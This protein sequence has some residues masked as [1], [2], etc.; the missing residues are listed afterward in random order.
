MTYNQ[1]GNNQNQTTDNQ[2]PI[3]YQ[4]QTTT[5]DQ[6]NDPS[7]NNGLKSMISYNNGISAG[8]IILIILQRKRLIGSGNVLSVS[9]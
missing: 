5:Y 3:N 6:I 4:D 7:S 8:V 9:C 2:K 1:M